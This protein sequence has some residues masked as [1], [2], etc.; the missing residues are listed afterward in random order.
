MIFSK[1]GKQIWKSGITSKGEWTFA[2]EE[3]S[4]EKQYFMAVLAPEIVDL[5]IITCIDIWQDVPGNCQ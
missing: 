2:S 4:I 3:N 5:A 1:Q